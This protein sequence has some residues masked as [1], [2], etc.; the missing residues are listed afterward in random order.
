MLGYNRKYFAFIHLHSLTGGKV[1]CQ[2]YHR[3]FRY[4]SLFAYSC[5]YPY[6]TFGNIQDICR[7]GFHILIIHT[8]EN[9]CE[10]ISGKAHGIFRIHFFIPDHPADRVQII[11]VF[12]HHLMD[13]KDHRLLFS[14]FHQCFL[15]QLLQLASG[16]FFC[17]F[18]SFHFCLGIFHSFL[19]QN[20]FL[21]FVQIYSSY[22]NPF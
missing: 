20:I 12:Q 13:I 10:I 9:T 3:F 4:N 1:V 7:T 16:G 21:L 22:C 11:F 8:C 6:Q 2:Q 14:G 17:L 5:K 19:L 15:I 18:E